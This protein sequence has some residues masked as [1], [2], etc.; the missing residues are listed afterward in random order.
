MADQWWLSPK[1]KSAKKVSKKPFEALD[2]TGEAAKLKEEKQEIEKRYQERLLLQTQRIEREQREVYSRERR[3]TQL[4]IKALQE[5][6]RLLAQKTDKLE[7]SLDQAAYQEVIEPSIYDISFLQRLRTWIKRFRERVENASIWLEVWNQKTKKR[8]FFWSMFASKK[9]GAQF[10]LSGE[11][12]L[13][14]SAG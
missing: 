9:G 7:K 1:K 14:R 5:E 13:S 12:Y 3:E 4:E 6:V 11:S 10:L 2:S 8:N